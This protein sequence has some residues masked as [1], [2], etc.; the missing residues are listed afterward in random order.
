MAVRDLLNAL[1]VAD[2]YDITHVNS[3][4]QDALREALKET[5]TEDTL[6]IFAIAYNWK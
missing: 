2:K 4:V 1:I 6:R 5:P 3:K